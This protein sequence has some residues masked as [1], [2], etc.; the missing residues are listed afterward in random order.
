M[1]WF[2]ASLARLIDSPHAA[3]LETLPAQLRQFTDKPH[4]D[5]RKWQR[6]L[7]QLPSLSIERDDDVSLGDTVT[8]GRAQQATDS[9]RAQLRGLLM[10][11]CPWRKGPFELFGMNIDTEWRSDWKWQR[12]APHINSLQGKQVLDVGCGSG[13]HLWR[14]LEAGA[15]DVWGVDPGELFLTQFQAIKKYMPTALAKRAHFFPVGIEQMPQLN[16]F[17]TV[18]SMGVLY[19]RRSPL[20]FL[21]QLKGL[22]KPGGQL[23]LE[24][25]VVEGDETTVMMPGERYAQ[26]RNVW[27]LPSAKALAVWMQRL[28]FT[29]IEVVDHN[30]TSLQEQRATDWMR[31]ESL[32]DFLD[33]NDHK[34]TIEG[35]KAPIRAILTART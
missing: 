33:P 31:G 12:V 26:M 19:H 1:D 14:M 24:T 23:V 8:V 34:M 11:L 27:F 20:E 32:A 15:A 30:T 3:W 17:D 28:G 7:K 13:Y 35:Y 21:Q 5:F 29:D 2:N 4:G 6:V 10:Q 22:L 18:F 16:S 9:Q 25:I